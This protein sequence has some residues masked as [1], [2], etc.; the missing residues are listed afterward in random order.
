MT[1]RLWSRRIIFQIQL[2]T[3]PIAE[4]GKHAFKGVS[5]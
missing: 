5:A 2:F 4:I 1:E 3:G